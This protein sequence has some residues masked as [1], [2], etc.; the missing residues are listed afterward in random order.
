MLKYLQSVD[1]WPVV[2]GAFGNGGAGLGNQMRG[3]QVLASVIRAL[4][5][6]LLLRGLLRLGVVLYYQAEYHRCNRFRQWP[7]NPEPVTAFIDGVSLMRTNLFPSP[8]FTDLYELTMAAGY[9][10][11]S[12]HARAVFS[13]FLRDHPQRGY[14]VAAGLESALTFL[15]SYQF[16]ADAISYIK[17]TGLFK[18]AL[19]EYLSTLRFT[20]DVRALPEG[21]L[22]FPDEPILEITAPIIEAQLLETFLINTIGLHTM[23]ATKAAR[24]IYAAQGRSL[25]DFALR[26]CQGIDAGMAVARSTYLTGFDATSNVLAAQEY[27]IPAVG[28]MAH[29]FIQ[30]IGDEKEAFEAYA[31][32]FPDRTVLLI[33]TYDTVEGARQAVE[34]ARQMAAAGH[35]L[36]GVR[37]DSG[38]MIALSRQVR[39]IFDD[40]GLP[41]VKIFASSGLDEFGLAGFVQGNAAIDAFGVGTKMGVSADLPYLDMV[42]KLVHYDTRDVRKLSPGKQTLA[43]EKQLFRCRD[44]QNRYLEDIIGVRGESFDPAQPLLETVM[45]SGQICVRLPS[46]G[47]IRQDFRSRFENLPDRYKQLS[48]PD[49]YP[50]RLSP[51]LSALQETAK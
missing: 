42:Y 18:P 3:L 39:K 51:A 43:G 50:V 34:V 48:H 38:D 40:A 23:I 36:V 17:Q 25:I 11:R 10:D 14:Y 22:F 49:A 5:S 28:T 7:L 35:S 45:Q 8:L 29:S 47:E 37:L 12:M 41:A 2:R 24:C 20:G 9:W 44:A 6:F 26:R 27:G 15:E 30:A 33:D 21:T 19:L 13:L 31:R 32:T 4:E 46:L 1:R 16:G